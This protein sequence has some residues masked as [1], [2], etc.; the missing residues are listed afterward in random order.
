M[1]NPW[2]SSIPRLIAV[3]ISAALYITA[4]VS[5]TR[6][7]KKPVA[8]P[9]SNSNGFNFGYNG[10]ERRIYPRA[11]LGVEIRYKLCT[12]EGCIQVFREG[13]ARD[14]S[15]GGIF[16]ETSEKLSVNDAL[17]LKLKLPN[18]S[19]FM[20]LRG[21]IVWAKDLD[22]GL[23]YNYGVSISEIDPN[24]RKQIAKYV[25]NKTD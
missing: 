8:I 19:H 9:D 22:Q 13:R 21:N 5:I 24:D 17:E 2:Y 1:H 3:I 23:W 7:P 10:P 6:R 14:I 20:L 25:S 4:L 11:L 15:E 12:K 16:L 18:M